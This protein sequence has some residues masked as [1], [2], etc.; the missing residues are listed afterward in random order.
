[1][2]A[3]LVL[4]TTAALAYTRQSLAVGELLSIVD[5]D[6]D[7]TILPAACVV[8]AAAQVDGVE[9][10]MLGLLISLPGV[11]VTPLEPELALAMGVL[12][13]EGGGVGL[14]HAATEALTHN[15]QVATRNAPAVASVLPPG[16]DVI[17]VD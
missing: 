16:W 14:A 8:E 12:V 9:L 10:T 15:A 4:D 11:E 5:E 7:T 6:G 3:A 17:E 2:S 13:R 1:M